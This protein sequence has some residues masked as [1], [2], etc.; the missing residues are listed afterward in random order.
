MEHK[1]VYN[2]GVLYVHRFLADDMARAIQAV[3]DADE[4]GQGQ[5]YVDAMERADAAV[6]RYR[7]ALRE[8]FGD[9]NREAP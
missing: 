4:R 5:P 7:A 9:E 2:K 8:C 3:L 6:K 1:L